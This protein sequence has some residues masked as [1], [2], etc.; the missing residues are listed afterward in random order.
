MNYID[1]DGTID[2][3]KA[4]LKTKSEVLNGEIIDSLI[5]EHYQECYKNPPLIEK[6]LHLLTDF[7][8]FRI[9]TAVPSVTTLLKNCQPSEVDDIIET[10]KVNKINY[11]EKLGVDKSRIIIVNGSHEKK[12][13]AK[14]N[15][16][17]DDY[18]KNIREW[19]AYGGIGVLVK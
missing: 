7:E 13:Y 15:T 8:D 16:L 6:N 19:V 11:M 2:D 1:M 4:W 9:L 12:L 18:E 3:F 10:L 5:V 17:Y 14:G